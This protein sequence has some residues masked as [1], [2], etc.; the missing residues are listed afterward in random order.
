MTNQHKEVILT[1]TIWLYEQRII[2]RSLYDLIYKSVV[3]L[4][5]DTILKKW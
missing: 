4:I 2:V 5:G 3:L 1:V